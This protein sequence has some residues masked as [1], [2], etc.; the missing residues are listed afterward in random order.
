MRNRERSDLRVCVI[1]AAGVL[2]L[3]VSGWAQDAPA[4]MMSAMGPVKPDP[5]ATMSRQLTNSGLGVGSHSLSI[6]ADQFDPITSDTTYAYLF[7]AAGTYIRVPTSATPG[8]MVAFFH[9]SFD[10]PSGA[11][12]DGV[13]LEAYDADPDFDIG[14]NVFV[15]DGSVAL[16]GCMTI[17]SA[18]TSGSP[19]ATYVGV[20]DLNETIDDFNKSY[21][22]EINA[23]S[24]DGLVGFRRALVT[25]HLQV[26]PAPG[27][28]SFG[29]VPK[30]S[31]QFQF[32]QALYEAGITAG[33][34][35]GNFCP[36]NPVTRGEMAVFLAKAL[37]LWWPN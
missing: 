27:S 31:P 28:S 12:L 37:G 18:S 22:I 26:S 10:L 6:N 24:F 30:S 20:G 8:H 11:V 5:R 9:G 36:S 33:C 25:Y 4:G 19:G 14:F 21:Y 2:T 35:G 16:N 13:K 34:G 17:G 32:I 1:A 3:A 29:D 15:C 7:V 23:G